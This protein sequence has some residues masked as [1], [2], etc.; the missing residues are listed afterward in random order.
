MAMD[1]KLE[2]HIK[3]V[4]KRTGEI[5]ALSDKMQSDRTRLSA[6]RGELEDSLREIE[7]VLEAS[8]PDKALQV[9]FEGKYYR[10]HKKIEDRK[11]VID[12]IDIAEIP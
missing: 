4:I 6:R 12:R 8:E 5:K 1:E 9:K 2:L 11:V 3:R 7:S 10:I